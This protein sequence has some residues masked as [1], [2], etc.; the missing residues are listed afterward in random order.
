MTDDR[1]RLRISNT[2]RDKAIEQLRLALDEGRID[3][4]EFD[5]RSRAV[6]DSKTRAELDIVFDDLPV[7]RAEDQAVHTV[8]LRP[9]ERVEREAGK[10]ERMRR[11]RIPASMHGLVWVATITTAIWLISSIASGY[12]NYF[13]PAWPIGIMAAI[14]FAQWLTG[15]KGHGKH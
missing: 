10:Q 5:E 9:E 12:V 3:L 1:G 4:T 6:Y 11:A 14:F 13:W 15:G 8:D 2:D 7:S